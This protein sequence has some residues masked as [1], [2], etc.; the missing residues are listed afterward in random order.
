MPVSVLIGPLS[1]LHDRNAH[2]GSL[3]FSFRVN[4]VVIAEDWA[5]RTEVFSTATVL[6]HSSELVTCDHNLCRAGVTAWN[7]RQSGRSMDGGW[8]TGKHTA[9]S[10]VLLLLL[11]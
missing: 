3:G 8:R 4:M 7:A 9:G 5:S 11:L 2:F 6:L 1:I 10:C